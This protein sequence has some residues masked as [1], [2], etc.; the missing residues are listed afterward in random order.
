MIGSFFDSLAAVATLSPVQEATVEAN[1]DAWAIEPET[2]IGNG[3]FMI[4]EWV[5]GSH[6]IMSKNPNYWNASAN[7]QVRPSSEVSQLSAWP[8]ANCPSSFTI[9][10]HSKE[11]FKEEDL[12]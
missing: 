12:L 10:R 8:G 4:T 9:K 7:V 1:G 6:I 5:P 11:F 2:Y 3:P